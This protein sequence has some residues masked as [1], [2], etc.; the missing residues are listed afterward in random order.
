[1]KVGECGNKEIY[2]VINKITPLVDPNSVVIGGWVI[3]GLNMYESMKRAQVLEWD[4]IQQLKPF[5]ENMYPFKA[6]YYEEFIA[7]N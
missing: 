2:E 4:L 3:S 6:I 5:T 7:E 1:M